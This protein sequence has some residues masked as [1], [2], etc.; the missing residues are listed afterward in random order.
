MVMVETMKKGCQ[1]GM[2]DGVF[3]FIVGTLGRIF[4]FSSLMLW[5]FQIS[6]SANWKSNLRIHNIAGQSVKDGV[7]ASD[8]FCS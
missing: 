8:G 4:S 5:I 1:W 3:A 6:A 7:N 2:V